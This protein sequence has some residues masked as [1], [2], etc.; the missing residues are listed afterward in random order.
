MN[1]NRRYCIDTYMPEYNDGGKF[2]NQLL[3]KNYL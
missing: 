2:F 3:I 1:Y